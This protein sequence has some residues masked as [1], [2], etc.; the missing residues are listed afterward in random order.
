M[1]RDLFISSIEAIK[2]QVYYDIEVSKNLSKAFPSANKDD[3]EPMNELLSDALINVLCHEMK[4][5]NDNKSWIKYFLFELN[6]GAESYRLHTNNHGKKV[7]M[8]NAGDL[9]DFLVL[10]NEDK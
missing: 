1:T 8:D 3:L 2:K 7:K 4:D 5:S 6:F 9:Y 10:I